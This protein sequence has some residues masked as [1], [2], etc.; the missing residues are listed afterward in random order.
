M[1]TNGEVSRSSNSSGSRGFGAD[2]AAKW[3]AEALWVETTKVQSRF[4]FCRWMLYHET[5]YSID[6]VPADGDIKLSLLGGTL[7][8]YSSKI[9]MSSESSVGIRRYQCDSIGSWPWKTMSTRSNQ[10]LLRGSWQRRYYEALILL[11]NGAWNSRRSHMVP[12]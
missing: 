2:A 11:A 4:F 10:A 12:R 7:T 8:G 6:Q 1:E 5:C 9:A 3:Q